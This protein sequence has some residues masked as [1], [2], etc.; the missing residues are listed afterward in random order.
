[1]YAQG[2]SMGGSLKHP[3]TGRSNPL[4]HS[5]V[6]VI[7]PTFNRLH[8]IADAI[9]SVLAQTH[10]ALEIIVVDDGSSDGSADWIAAHYPCVQLL[11]QDN[12]GVSH[13][14]NRAIE[15]AT[16]DWLALLDSDDRWYANKLDVQMTALAQ[17]PDYRLCHCDEHWFRNGRRVN[18]KVK[19]QKHGGQIFAHCLPL[20]A[21]SP[22]AAVIHRSLFAELGQFDESLPACED[23]DLWLR[24]CAQESVLYIDQALLA[25]TGGH[26]DQLS[27]RYWGMD[28]FRLQS[29][30]KVLQSGKLTNEQYALAHETFTSK[31]DIYLNGASKRGREDEVAALRRQYQGILDDA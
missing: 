17:Q 30:A 13:A 26:E 25:K 18:P 19:H 9:E 21:I 3:V 31:L 6:S 8:C 4:V 14:R 20:C 16:G 2:L 15:Q 23:Y 11:R 1:M 10:P 27:Q 29:L 22:S 12:H 24:F 5:T 28:R 7:I